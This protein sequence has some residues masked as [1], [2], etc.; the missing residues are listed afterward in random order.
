MCVPKLLVIGNRDTKLLDMLSANT[1]I[2]YILSIL[3]DS[4]PITRVGLDLSICG[5]VGNFWK[6]IERNFNNRKSKINLNYSNFEQKKDIP[7]ITIQSLL[8]EK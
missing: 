4:S 5:T 3:F 7:S 6:I 2:H 1:L 8:L